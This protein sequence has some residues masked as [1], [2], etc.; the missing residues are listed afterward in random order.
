MLQQEKHK[1]LTLNYWLLKYNI[2]AILQ[3]NANQL[4]AV[5]Y[6]ILYY[7]K[8]NHSEKP[9]FWLFNSFVYL[10]VQIIYPV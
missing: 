9:A 2:P 4:Q 1:M 5:W 8:K 10:F 3:K 7:T 6:L